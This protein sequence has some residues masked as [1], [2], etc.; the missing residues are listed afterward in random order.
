MLPR[1]RPGPTS[2]DLQVLQRVAAERGFELAFL[3]RGQVV[4]EL[5][6]KAGR[7]QPG[8]RVA[9]EDLAFVAGV[10][11]AADSPELAG[12]TPGR[13]DTLQPVGEAAFGGPAAGADRQLGQP[14]SRGA[15][16]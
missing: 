13:E 11:D 5:V 7:P 12:R 4:V 16:R 9:F 1:L 3:D 14:G 8:D 15:T 6:R 10:L 2:S